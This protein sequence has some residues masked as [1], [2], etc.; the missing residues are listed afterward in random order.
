MYRKRNNGEYN[1]LDYSRNVSTYLDGFDKWLEHNFIK[2]PGWL[3]KYFRSESDYKLLQG[4]SR[5]R[6]YE[7]NESELAFGGFGS[8]KVEITNNDIVH[9]YGKSLKDELKAKG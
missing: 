3:K 1:S 9:D 8:P 7:F 5:G 2:T 4:S 6:Y